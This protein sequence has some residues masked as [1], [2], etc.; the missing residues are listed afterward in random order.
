[1]I[2][3]TN[4]VLIVL[5]TAILALLFAVFSAARVLKK[6]Q[7]SEKMKE[8]AKA[9]QQGASAYLKRQYKIVFIIVIILTVLF[10]FIFNLATAVSFILGAVLSALAGYLGM[11]ISVRANVRTA[12]A[13]SK[14]LKDALS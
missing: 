11:H 13:A 8:I 2:E 7:G 6:D 1:M 3:I 14:G 10:G 5:G 12:K 4:N 9:I